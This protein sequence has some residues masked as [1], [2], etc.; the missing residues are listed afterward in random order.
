[1]VFVAAFYHNMLHFDEQERCYDS[2]DRRGKGIRKRDARPQGRFL[3][4]GGRRVRLPGGPV[5][6]G[7]VHHHQ[8][9]HRRD[10]P[11]G[12]PGHGQRLLHE[13]HPRA[14]D[15]LYAPHHR[16]DLSGFPPHRQQDGV[17]QPGPGHAGSGR[18]AQGAA[19][20]HP[21]RLGTGGSCGQ[22]QPL[23][24]RAV[25]RRTAARGHR[26]G[27]GEQPQHHRGGRAHRQP[28]PGPLPG[29]HDAAGAHQRPGHD[30]DRRHSRAGTGE[31]FQQA[32]HPAQR[33]ARHR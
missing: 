25:R 10:R 5:R 20:P 29:D 18:T 13:P 23:S 8:A 27:A 4:S 15:T 3:Y 16:R 21:L 6:V 7:Q 26:P 1:M 33:G 22:G 17:R 28:R 2:F 31:P 24:R 32:Y 19:K 14:A 30:G 12:G 9:A 11:H